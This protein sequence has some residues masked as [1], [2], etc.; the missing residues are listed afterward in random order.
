MFS[1]QQNITRQTKKK[2]DIGVGRWGI[3][4]VFQE[5]GERRCVGGIEKAHI[6]A[7]GGTRTVSRALCLSP[8]QCSD[9]PPKGSML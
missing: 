2:E 7:A 4:T 8:G 5:V 9:V 1:L 6:V 3:C